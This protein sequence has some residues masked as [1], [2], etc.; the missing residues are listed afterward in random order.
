MPNDRARIEILNYKLKKAQF[1]DFR[2]PENPHA[3]DL[4]TNERYFQA[5]FLMGYNVEGSRWGRLE[6]VYK[7]G[8]AVWKHP[9]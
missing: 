4:E 8:G 2:P 5:Q 6:V 3:H 9:T 7:V 1:S